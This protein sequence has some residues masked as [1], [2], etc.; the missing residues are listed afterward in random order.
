MIRT[1]LNDVVKRRLEELLGKDLTNKNEIYHIVS[2]ELGV[3]RV[4]VR[5]VAS[6]LRQE[7]QN[8]INILQSQNTV[9]VD[10]K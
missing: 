2:N 3:H 1:N 4:V 10:S 7:Y 5:R 8:R 6:E 9:K